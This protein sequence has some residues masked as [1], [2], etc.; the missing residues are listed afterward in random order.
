MPHLSTPHVYEKAGGGMNPIRGKRKVSTPSF[1]W[2]L[3]APAGQGLT[4][5]PQFMHHTL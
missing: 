3:G 1:G 2:T 4:L 5:L